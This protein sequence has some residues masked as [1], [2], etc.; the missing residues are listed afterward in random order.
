MSTYQDELSLKLSAK[1]E[2]SATTRQTRQEITKTEKAL[3]QARKE[4]NDTGSKK[5]A[6]DMRKLEKELRD[7]YATQ[8]KVRKET[9]ANEAALKRLRNEAG[10]SQTAAAKV[11]RAWKGTASIFENNVLAGI[12]AVGLYMGG[13]QLLGAF[14]EAEKYQVKLDLAAQKFGATQH[15]NTEE[16]RAYNDVLM[17]QTAADDDLLAAGEAKL[18]QYAL[19][20]AQIRELIPLVNDFARSEDVDLLTAA[21]Q[22][23]K[24]LLGNTRA[25]KAVGIS[26]KA[27]GD[28]AKDY[29]AILDALR[30][31]V[32]GQAAAF[33]ATEAGKIERTRVEFE[34]LQ[35]SL[36]E[37]LVPALDA[38][39]GT[40]EPV[41][42]IFT[43]MPDEAKQVAV[44]LGFIGAAALV[45]TPQI[46]AMNAA[47]AAKGY[48]G[49]AA[50]AGR[51]KGVAASLGAVAAAYVAVGIAKGDSEHLF[52][53]NTEVDAEAAMKNVLNPTFA[54]KVRNVFEKPWDVFRL[55]RSSLDIYQ[56]K[57]VE[58][59]AQLAAMVANGEADKAAA[60]YREM[61][62]YALDNGASL[63][64]LSDSMPGYRAAMKDY[65]ASIAGAG[66]AHSYAARKAYEQTV[67]EEGLAGALTSIDRK[68]AQRDAM[69]A[70]QAALDAFVKNP[71][72]ETG[73]AVDKALSAW[74]KTYAKPERQAKVIARGFDE[75]SAAVAKSGIS[76][77]I[78]DKIID[79]LREANQWAES[80]LRLLA[81]ENVQDLAVRNKLFALGLAD[82]GDV[83]G[84]G[85][86]TSDSIPAMLSNGEHVTRA[87]ATA[88]MRSAFGQDIMGAI[89]TFDRAP[90]RLLARIAAPRAMTPRITVKAGTTQTMTTNVTASGQIDYELA[91]RRMARQAAREARARFAGSGR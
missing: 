30:N 47:L 76:D 10:R 66:D 86:G 50:V 84:P 12:T 35:E 28:Q 41:M 54:A 91:Q 51:Y 19:T 90:Q 52:D 75:I 49:L 62:R 38:V 78:G 57:L 22:I 14:S 71:S 25:L 45:L 74:S 80:L 6:D 16:L 88:A 34:N 39:L 23:G 1:D 5:A 9:S 58:V 2:L 83:R 20:G 36:G 26:Y 89:N 55:S 17:R 56:D 68:L 67:A 24:G 15:I 64:D 53:W 81:G 29:A 3:Q 60:Q 18:A 72:Q 44:G 27:T 85:T 70:Y 33:G 13:R 48:G 77:K 61:Q 7:L 40:A 31:K 46:T 43:A 42:D 8:A 82:G 65:A 21:E 11:G 4:F 37:Q 69:R 79:P 59:D 73:E 32:G 87:R 63:T